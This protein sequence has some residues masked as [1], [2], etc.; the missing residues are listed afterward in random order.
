M[1]DT[2][3]TQRTLLQRA[4][5]PNDQLAWDDFV[6]F[7]TPFIHKVLHYMNLSAPDVDDV[8]QEVLLK[9]WQHLSTFDKES[10]QVLFRTWLGTIIR[11]TAISFLRKKSKYTERLNIAA[12]H[13]QQDVNLLS[14]S[15]LETMIE[16][17]WKSHVANKALTNV[18]KL[19]TG[20]AIQAFKLSLMGQSTRKI[21]EQL[22]I[23][24][25]SV[26]T[27]QNRVK[28]RLMKEI[29]QLRETMEF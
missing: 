17:E 1:A 2:W 25:A 4:Q 26:H 13:S 23:T 18:T 8:T 20:V 24:Q 11:N 14:E 16:L 3:K 15:K 9:I 12:N 21:S 19:F 29:G 22:N 27:L 28:I 5:D 7:Y 6:G 10:H